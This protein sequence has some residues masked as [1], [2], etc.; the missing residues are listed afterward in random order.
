MN[1]ARF[2]F[3]EAKLFA[4]ELTPR[5]QRFGAMTDLRDRAG[6]VAPRDF[7]AMLAIAEA[8]LAG[9][10]SL[11]DQITAAFVLQRSIRALDRKP[12][13]AKLQVVAVRFDKLLRA[14]GVAREPGTAS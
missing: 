11:P 4:A 9:E 1:W 3:G 10:G 13:G 6:R 5:G 8:V 2:R 14:L 12:S 7:E